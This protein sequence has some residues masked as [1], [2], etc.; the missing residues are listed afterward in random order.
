M[1]GRNIEE[2]IDRVLALVPETETALRADLERVKFGSRFRAP[3]TMWASWEAGTNV[4][5]RHLSERRGAAWV[6]SVRKV[7]AG[8]ASS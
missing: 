5:L 2:V 1:S 7:W 4:L 8:E 6:E 3:E